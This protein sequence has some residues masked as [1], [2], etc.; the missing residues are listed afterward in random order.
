MLDGKGGW[1]GDWMLQG[2]VSEQFGRCWNM[3]LDGQMIDV[4]KDG[5]MGGLIIE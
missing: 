4:G 2:K 5:C 1:K 3:R